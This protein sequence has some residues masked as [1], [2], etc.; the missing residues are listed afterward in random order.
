LP[1]PLSLEQLVRRKGF[2]PSRHRELLAGRVLP[3]PQLAALQG[4]Y[5]AAGSEPERREIAV[6]FLRAVT[7]GAGPRPEIEGRLL[8]IIT[9]PPVVWDPKTGRTYVDRTCRKI[10][11]R[12]LVRRGLDVDEAAARMNVSAATVKAYLREC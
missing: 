10:W 3:W 1:A 8:K 11:A 7:A 9:G 2:R 12:E 4:E 6:R 5:V